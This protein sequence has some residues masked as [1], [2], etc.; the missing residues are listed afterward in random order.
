MTA[1]SMIPSNVIDIP[2][3]IL[4]GRADFD[5]VQAKPAR[6]NPKTTSLRVAKGRRLWTKSFGP[7]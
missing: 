2:V 1:A 7:I 4:I 3:P 5:R 6:S